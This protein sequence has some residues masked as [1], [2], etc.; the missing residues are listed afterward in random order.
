MP[1]PPGQCLK[2]PYVLL[3]SDKECAVRSRLDLAHELGHICIH[4]A[5]PESTLNKQEFFTLIERQA[6]RFGSAFL[7]P[8]KAFLDD[9]FDFVRCSE[10]VE[11]QMA[12]FGRNDA[13]TA[14]DALKSSTKINI[15]ACE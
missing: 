12:R 6:F 7:L 13:R 1:F 4:Q 15:G 5:I 14:E 10:S 3:N 8:E 11:T 9:V 2:V